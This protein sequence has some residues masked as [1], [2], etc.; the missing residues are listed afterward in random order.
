MCVSFPVVTVDPGYLD[1]L[2]VDEFLD[3]M[4]WC[5]FQEKFSSLSTST[6]SKI[7]AHLRPNLGKYPQMK[8]WYGR[9]IR[10]PKVSEDEKNRKLKLMSVSEPEPLN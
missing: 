7:T 4:L 10:K 6:P 2:D 5:E 9:I 1:V 3:F 8:Q